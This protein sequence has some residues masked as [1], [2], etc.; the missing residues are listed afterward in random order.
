MILDFQIN[1]I[2]QI[3]IIKIINCI[4]DLNDV[5]EHHKP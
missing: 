4:I 5:N 2:D 1:F 3:L